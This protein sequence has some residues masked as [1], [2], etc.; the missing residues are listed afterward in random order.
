MQQISINIKNPANYAAVLAV[1]LAILGCYVIGLV[2]ARRQDK[3]DLLK[4]SGIL[5]RY[6]GC[7]AVVR[8]FK[9]LSGLKIVFER[10]S[11]DSHLIQLVSWGVFTMSSWIETR[12]SLFHNRVHFKYSPHGFSA[13][14][15]HEVC[16]LVFEGV[17]KTA[18]SGSQ[19]FLSETLSYDHSLQTQHRDSPTLFEKFV[20]SFRFPDRKSPRLS[21]GEPRPTA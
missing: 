1:L 7:H 18:L 6:K 21:H 9:I 3:R 11:P 12:K 5:V 17:T 4:V 8:V 2:W 14:F 16:G 15:T 19:W 13:T 20:G 10:G